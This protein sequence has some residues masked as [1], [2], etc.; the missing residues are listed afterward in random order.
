MIYEESKKA[1]LQVISTV[2]VV[3]LTIVWNN[4]AT[5][6]YMGNQR[7]VVK[8]QGID[9]G[10]DA[11]VVYKRA[12]LLPQALDE[13]VHTIKAEALVSRITNIHRHVL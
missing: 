4:Y 5:L 11:I 13:L 7:K 3:E 8:Q 1:G 2:C 9:E 10:T 6:I 12:G